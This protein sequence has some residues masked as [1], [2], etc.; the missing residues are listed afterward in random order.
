M[1]PSPSFIKRSLAQPGIFYDCIDHA[2]SFDKQSGFNQEP[3]SQLYNWIVKK[4]TCPTTLP[5]CTCPRS[6]FHISHSILGFIEI[7]VH[8]QMCHIRFMG[9]AMRLRC[10]KV[11]K[12][13]GPKWLNG[14]VHCDHRRYP[15]AQYDG[16]ISL[17]QF[18]ALNTK[19]ML[20][21]REVPKHLQTVA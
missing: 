2:F 18:V 1:F 6:H 17:A 10:N 20:V 9:L 16:M 7:K 11:K 4:A 5:T 14:K 19:A 15:R 21:M 13:P 12:T 8:L 3:Q